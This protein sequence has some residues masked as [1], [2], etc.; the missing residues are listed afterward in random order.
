VPLALLAVYRRDGL[1]LP[2]N[3]DDVLGMDLKSSESKRAPREAGIHVFE[4]T[5][6]LKRISHARWSSGNGDFA[7]RV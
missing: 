3:A 6:I 5:H 4:I 2:A 1:T 7:V